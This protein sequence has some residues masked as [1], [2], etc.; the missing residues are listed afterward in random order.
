MNIMETSGNGGSGTVN[1]ADP[2]RMQGM[3]ELE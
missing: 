1:S 3:A 2:G